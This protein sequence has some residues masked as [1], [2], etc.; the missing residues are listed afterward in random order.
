ML[1][2]RYT[3]G[4]GPGVAGG[5][6]VPHGHREQGAHQGAH[7]AAGTN[8]VGL[9]WIRIPC[10]ADPDS[11]S[12]FGNQADQDADPDPGSKKLT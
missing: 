8:I 7:Q 10:N 12:A 4:S 5:E 1:L 6:V 11:G 3:N 2:L 9:V